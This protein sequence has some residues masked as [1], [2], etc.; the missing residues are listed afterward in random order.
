MITVTDNLLYRLYE[1]SDRDGILRLWQEESGWGGLTIQQF[2][3]WFLKTPYGKCIIVVAVN[4]ADTI[5]GQII[6]SP[7]RMMVDE[8]EIKSLRV[9]APILSSA[10]RQGNIKDYNHPAFSMIR[11]GFELANDAGYQY[12]YSFPAFGWL[13]LLRLLPKFLPNPSD[14]AVFSCFSTALNDAKTF[15]TF[16]YKYNVVITS[17]FSK[18]HT[19][20]WTN[21]VKN[22]PVK[23]G[24]VR[25]AKW[26]QWVFGG[27][28]VLETR[29]ASDNRL[30]GYMAIKKETGLI[31]D[32]LAGNETD[33]K[34]VFLHSI[35][36]LHQQNT[37]RIPVP[38]TQLKGMITPHTK[39]I[40]ECIGYTK[41]NYRFAFG[42]YLLDTTIPF[43]K[44]Q[45]ANWYITPMG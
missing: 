25:E 16:K 9:S 29:A 27:H 7:S 3:S 28:L 26:L 18:V 34:E 2:E 41:D 42:S 22:L 33:L 30:I 24:V 4:N 1:E 23:C 32:V 11:K 44:V 20:L 6:Y 8:K 36:A 17:T 15:S 14:T 38:F 45:T 13:G 40:L 21:A 37:K 39:P 43:E 35:N 10:F 12:I 31:V 19:D 5:V